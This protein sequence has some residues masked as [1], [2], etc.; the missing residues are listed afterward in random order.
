MADAADEVAGHHPGEHGPARRGGHPGALEREREHRRGR[1]RELH[2]RRD[3]ER[4]GDHADGPG[5]EHERVAGA[6]G[7]D[8]VADVED[9]DGH[10]G[11]DEQQRRR[12]RR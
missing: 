2:A 5:R 6:A 4:A 1:E 12:P 7:A 11:G 9:L 3:A 8:D 10:R